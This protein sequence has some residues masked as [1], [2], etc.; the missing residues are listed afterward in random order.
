M[1]KNNPRISSPIYVPL[2][3]EMALINRPAVSFLASFILSRLSQG[4]QERRGKGGNHNKA[5]LVLS[6]I[7]GGE[8]T[9]YQR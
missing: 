4:R 1:I 2:Q 7:T 8:P 6:F 3:A 9:N 5:F